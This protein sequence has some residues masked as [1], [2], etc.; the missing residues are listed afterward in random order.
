MKTYDEIVLD[1]IKEN[2]PIT[3]NQLAIELGYINS[4]SIWAYMNKL[5]KDNQ[6]LK[7]STH[8]PYQYTVNE[9]NLK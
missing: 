9:V 6:I 8:K 2:Q 5:V 1:K 4:N 3:A 7:D